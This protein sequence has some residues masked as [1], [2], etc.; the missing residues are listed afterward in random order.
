MSVVASFILYFWFKLRTTL[1]P[2]NHKPKSQPPMPTDSTIRRLVR[3]NCG[4]SNLTA[5]CVI[6]IDNMVLVWSAQRVHY[7]GMIPAAP[8]QAKQPSLSH[9]TVT[10]WGHGPKRTSKQTRKEPCTDSG[11]ERYT[12]ATLATSSSILA[13]S[14]RI[15]TE[16]GRARRHVTHHPR[17]T[18]TISYS[19]R[20]ASLDG[21]V[22]PNS[23]TGR[24]EPTAHIFPVPIEDRP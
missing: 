1:S 9:A 18:G 21:Q 3:S 4:R 14:P 17:S 24:K 12:L 16:D 10:L 22:Q 2:A 13:S 8:R 15:G 20:V 23:S 11:A 7:L 19:R 6:R 5:R